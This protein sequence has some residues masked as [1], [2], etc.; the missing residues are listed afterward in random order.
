MPLRRSSGSISHRN[1][2]SW[3]NVQP[4]F[5]PSA[6]VCEYGCCK[7]LLSISCP[8]SRVAA[9]TRWS[10]PGHFAASLMLRRLLSRRIVCFAA[11]GHFASSSTGDRPTPRRSE[12]HTSELQSHS[13]LVCRLLPDK[14]KITTSLIRS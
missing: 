10:S 14:K 9:S 1:C 6:A 13:D 5:R 4:R 3:Q 7:A 12:E 8:P 11:E 2:C